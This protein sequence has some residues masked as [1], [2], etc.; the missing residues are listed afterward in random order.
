MALAVAT[1]DPCTMCYDTLNGRCYY[2]SIDACPFQKFITSQRPVPFCHCMLCL[3]DLDCPLHPCPLCDG[4]HVRSACPCP[5]DTFAA[6]D[7]LFAA[8]LF[9]LGEAWEND[10]GYG[11][12][13]YEE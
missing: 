13:D 3:S 9:A 2:H 12:N 1:V 5:A 11:A 7:S 10:P 4:P 6:L 8:R